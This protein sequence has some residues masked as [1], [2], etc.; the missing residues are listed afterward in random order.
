M[1]W[2]CTL[3]HVYTLANQQGLNDNKYYRKSSNIGPG[4][5][6]TQA[7]RGPGLYWKEV[8]IRDNIA[9]S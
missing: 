5:Y 7:H 3:P 8:E 9:N 4:L 1:S 6:F 2:L